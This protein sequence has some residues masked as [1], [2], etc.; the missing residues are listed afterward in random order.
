[1]A[2][3]VTMTLTN[4]QVIHGTSYRMSANSPPLPS[5]PASPSPFSGGVYHIQTQRGWR[6]F[7]AS[8]VASISVAPGAMT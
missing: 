8:D 3:R 2:T 4:G 7:V 5:V 6:D 1:M